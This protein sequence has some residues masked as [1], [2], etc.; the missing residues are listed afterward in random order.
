MSKN[1]MAWEGGINPHI[2]GN[3]NAQSC[4]L[5]MGITSENVAAKYGLSRFATIQATACKRPSPSVLRQEPCATG[6]RRHEAC[7]Q[8]VAPGGMLRRHCATCRSEQD[9][10]AA[11]S[12]RR[13][14]A[15]QAAGKF[16]KEIVPVKTTVIDPKTK[17]AKPVTVTADD[18][19]RAGTS[20]QSLAKLPPAFK[21]GGS[22]TAGNSSQVRPRHRSCVCARAGREPPSTKHNVATCGCSLLGSQ[23]GQWH[24]EEDPL[25]LPVRCL[26]LQ[27]LQAHDP[28][29]CR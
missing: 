9:A 4:L 14:A 24:M 5:P 13:A 6:T 8:L 28:R 11:E 29:A 12:H 19:I 3:K 21:Q 10:F 26:S 17:E 2:E 18:G 23:A 27:P 20:L 15:A 1:P 25:P 16:V 22:T 7:V